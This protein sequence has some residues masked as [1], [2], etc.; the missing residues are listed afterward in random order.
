MTFEFGNE[1]A[2]LLFEVKESK[3]Y[4]K[5]VLFLGKNYVDNKNGDEISR[6]LL[7][8]GQYPGKLFSRYGGKKTFE[9]LTYI[10]HSFQ[11]ESGKK[12][13]CIEE[14]NEKLGVKSYFSIYKN[15][16][17][18]A[19]WKE[20]TNVC[21]RE[22]DLEC[23]NILALTNV[24]CS[25][26]A[27]RE[28]TKKTEYGEAF[29]SVLSYAEEGMSSNGLPY[30]WVAQNSWCT[31]AVFERMDLAASG[32]RGCHKTKRC[33]KICISSNGSQ[34]TS[35]YLP[36]G[37]LERESF[38][39][40]M[41]ELTPSGSWAYEIEGGS[42]DVDDAEVRLV[43]TGKTLMDNGWYRT[44]APQESY[45]TDEV[46]I[47]GAEDLDG[48][49]EQFTVYRRNKRMQFGV[50]ASSQVIYNNFQQNTY[51]HPTSE[52]DVISMDMAKAMGCDYY[53]VDAGWHDD[54]EN[55]ISPTQ[56]IGE[57]EENVA[58][59]PNGF[60]ETVDG[61]RTRG[62]K[63]GLWVELQ[64]IGFY[65]KNKE[66]LSEECFFHIN[67][68]RPISNNRYQLDFTKGKTREFATGVID[69]IVSRYAPDYIKIDYN[70][71]V[72]GNDC[73]QGSLTEGLALH[74]R[75]Y[76]Q[77]FIEIQNKYPQ[78][79]FESCASGGMN[80]DASKA[81]ITNVFSITDAGTYSI[82]PYILANVTLATLPEQNGIWNMP[83]RRI[84][85]P[86]CKWNTEWITT[87]EEV[88]MNAVN[89]LYG[90]MHLSSHLEKLSPKQ[91]ELIKEGIDYYREIAE[92][93]K[94]AVPVFPNG[95]TSLDDN[96]VY[97][98]LKTKNK[99]YLSVYNLSEETVK[100][101]KNLGKY[102]AADVIYA[103]PRK[104]ETKHN[105][106]KGIFT[107]ELPPLSARAFEFT[108]KNN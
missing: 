1:Y 63:F 48:I 104:V 18:I 64:S 14:K 74:V 7:T 98:A 53:V 71:T 86:S 42:G 103:Y 82:Y 27:Q 72:Y 105:L 78:I 51:D 35:R 97:L 5:Q 83:M 16:G 95:F 106:W 6:I 75:A 32:L 36:L 26:E 68:K 101:S 66:I 79:L 88:I 91:Q 60:K 19:T 93:K 44:L 87:D 24:M 17:V 62:M 30:L 8:D 28:K 92:A 90:I 99:L 9:P 3:A 10:T 39:M 20:I 33:G 11:E 59:Y 55:N 22:L 89:A 38:G 29:S 94:E 13:L 46:K 25:A 12:V 108:L 37:I 41:F 40:F 100:V 15:S 81:D 107:C 45:L 84:F 54:S 4:I 43:I 21:D 65:A 56:K 76:N 50:D 85:Y 102:Q 73:E 57:W 61:A 58:S 31:E 67:G 23:A 2:K 69:K 80:I 96:V 52:T 49:A 47:V 70:Q 77:W 34:V